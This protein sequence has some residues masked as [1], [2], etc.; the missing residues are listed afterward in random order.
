META[1]DPAALL[2]DLREH[3]GED[4]ELGI[5]GGPNSGISVHLPWRLSGQRLAA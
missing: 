4:T 1:V 5:P 3:T 2:A